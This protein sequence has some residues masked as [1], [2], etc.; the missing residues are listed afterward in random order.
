M[1]KSAARER[2][3]P[4]ACAFSIIL[5]TIILPCPPRMEAKPCRLDFMY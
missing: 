1:G 4:A 5:P 2:D 3:S